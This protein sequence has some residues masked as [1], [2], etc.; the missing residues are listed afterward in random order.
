[1]NLR[2]PNRQRKSETGAGCCLVLV[3]AALCYFGGHTVVAIV[4][5]ALP[6]PLWLAVA[7]AATLL[8]GALASTGRPE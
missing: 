4:R 6:A 5:D 8:A 2:D 7:V 3:V 1:M